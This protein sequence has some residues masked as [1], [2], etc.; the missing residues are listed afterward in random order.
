LFPL[1]VFRVVVHP[2]WGNRVF[3]RGFASGRWVFGNKRF[4]FQVQDQELG[5]H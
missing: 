3:S 5:D 4:G 1:P 2:L